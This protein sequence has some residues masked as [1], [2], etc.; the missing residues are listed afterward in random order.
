[1]DHHTETKS[2][3]KKEITRLGKKAEL[4]NN[5][6][7]GMNKINE[8]ISSDFGN[9]LEDTYED[10]ALLNKRLTCKHLNKRKEEDESYH[11][12]DISTSYYCTNCE[13]L[14]EHY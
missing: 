10:I 5:Y 13:L 9:E 2:K 1:M 12:G 4:L 11:N 7:N 3:I 6:I 14:L 8:Y